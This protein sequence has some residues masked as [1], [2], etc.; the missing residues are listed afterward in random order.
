M[1]CSKNWIRRRFSGRA[2]L[3]EKMSGNDPG[4]KSVQPVKLKNTPHLKKHLPGH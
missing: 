4:E 3:H 2:D 1:S